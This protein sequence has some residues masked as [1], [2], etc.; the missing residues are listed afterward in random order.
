MN[1]LLFSNTPMIF[2]GVYPKNML[3]PCSRKTGC[4]WH[5][6]KVM[7]M[8]NYLC[9]SSC[10]LLLFLYYKR[11]RESKCYTTPV[12]SNLRNWYWNCYWKSLAYYS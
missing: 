4:R 5:L 3:H 6:N 2:L 9:I 12:N 8:M 1:H 10:L 7:G 11:R